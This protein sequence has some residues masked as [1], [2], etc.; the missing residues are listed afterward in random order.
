M[1]HIFT[2]LV[3]VCAVIGAAAQTS[4]ICTDSNASLVLRG[5]YN[6][7]TYLASSIVSDHD[8]ISL[9]INS[10]VSAD[11]LRAYLEVLKTFVTRN[12]GSDTVSNTIGVGAARRWVF[13]K[14]QQFSSSNENRLLP[15]YLQFD[16]LMCNVT[17]HRNIMAVL[18]GID[19]SDK[20]IVIVEGHIDSRN[21]NLCDTAGIA[22]GME[23][24]ASGTAL[25]MELA[26]VMSR[27]SYQHT[28]VFLVTVGEE[29]GLY[30]ANA[31]AEYAALN[32]IK[33]KAVLNNDVVGGIICGHT[34]SAPGCPGF[35]NIDST[36]VRLFSY[37]GFNSFHKGL[38]RYIKLAYN[39]RVL[40]VAAVPMGINIMTP[41][42]RTG[43]G[44][45]HIPFRAHNF[46][47]MRFTAANE[48]GDANVADTSYIDRQHTSR[49]SLGIDAD[50]D[51]II[52]TFY[53]DFDYLGR[54]T[55]IN[56]N[57]AGM[58]A[59]SPQTPDFTISAYGSSIIIQI[60]QHPEYLHYKVGVRSTTY[61]WD[62]VYEF[63]GLVDTIA[64]TSGHYIVSVCSVD[65]YGVESL[66]SRELMQATGVENVLPSGQKITLLQNKPN[67][68][69]EATTI[70][71][72][73]DDKVDYKEAYISIADLNG[74]EIQ[75]QNIVLDK[76]VNEIMYNHGY[77]AS[78]TY[79]YTLVVDG[80]AVASKKMMFT[81]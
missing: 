50:G 66:F 49:D 22:Q 4:I 65:E 70:A 21:A 62:S 44:G 59:I 71:V 79:V 1:K 57:A 35:D 72:E 39:E 67:P 28:I 31:F 11:S 53:V 30:G 51:G 43:R 5:N 23:D 29:Q 78:G 34:S 41:E 37:G 25:V 16:Y 56:G 32:G 81:N 55:V 63:T 40:P 20:S 42:D 33:I 74:K 80:K 38:A 45:D 3:L 58:I 69:D 68:S 48:S 76:G 10:S 46:A 60:T 18:P 7:S 9:G 52:D 17:Q 77:H 2:T 54:N 6:P 19:T 75:R 64:L 26:R 15:C 47:A 13:S 27:F 14:F 12:S 24:N 73:V 36:H 61:D 8:S